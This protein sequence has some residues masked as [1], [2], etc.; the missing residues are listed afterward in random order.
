M[1]LSLNG[2][3][4][5]IEK[6]VIT[7]GLLDNSPVHPREVF[8]DAIADRATSVIFAHNHPSGNPQPSEADRRMHDRLTEAGR[9]LG[10]RVLDH[11]IVTKKRHFSFQASGLIET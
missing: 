5:L 9:I 10:L 2:A 4:E 1:C 8:A 11:V 3:N 6:R 7:I